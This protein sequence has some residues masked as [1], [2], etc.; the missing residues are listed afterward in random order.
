MR[1]EVVVSIPVRS[2]N[3][4]MP[5]GSWIKELRLDYLPVKDMDSFVVN[6]NRH[7]RCILTIRDKEEGGNYTGGADQKFSILSRS[8][9]PV[10]DIE[11]RHLEKF[12]DSPIAG[13]NVI[14]SVHNFKGEIEP[15][16]I[17]RMLS[18]ITSV[19]CI[20]KVAMKIRNAGKYLELASEHA[21]KLLI[22][23]MNS[24][25]NRILFAMLS[26][27][28]LYSSFRESVAPNQP[29]YRLSDLILDTVF[30]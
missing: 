16:L 22:V 4:E 25:T 27:T 14:F 10:V 12:L 30:R 13:K 1:P 26:G 5:Q 15:N 18:N 19:D 21:G 20:L 28:Y 29:N 2:L 23:D 3:P 17:E 6:E 9:C 7:G 8:T 11:Y 24:L